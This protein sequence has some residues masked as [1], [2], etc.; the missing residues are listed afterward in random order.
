MSVTGAGFK[1]RGSLPKAKAR[2]LD[3]VHMSVDEG[4]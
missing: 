3:Q 4:I 2:L 1:P